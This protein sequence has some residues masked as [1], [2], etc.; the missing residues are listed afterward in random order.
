MKV[1]WHQIIPWLL[2][3]WPL[4]SL[5][6]VIA[7]HVIAIRT[8]PADVLMVN[9]LVGMALQVLGSLLVL[10]SVNDN[11]GIFRSKS[12][13]ATVIDWFRSFPVARKPITLSASGC[14]SANRLESL[15]SAVIKRASTLE[16][17][18]KEVERILSELRIQVTEEVKTLS[19]QIE[20]AKSELRRQNDETSSRVSDLSKRLE[21][22]VVGSFKFQSLGVLLAFY[23][24]V[25]SVFA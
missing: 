5:V 25:T 18:I 7:V 9:K 23:G 17:R 10:Y 1:H 3:A 21:H 8:F 14:V 24:A 2:R 20:D 16:E 19:R 22:T 12:L 13:K 15:P 4:L 6:P 11:L